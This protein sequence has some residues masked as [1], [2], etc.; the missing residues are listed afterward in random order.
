[1]SPGSISGSLQSKY[2]WTKAKVTVRKILKT[3][4]LISFVSC[5]FKAAHSQRPETATGNKMRAAPQTHKKTDGTRFNQWLCLNTKQKIYWFIIIIIIIITIIVVVVINFSDQTISV[6]FNPG[7]KAQTPWCSQC[8]F[9]PIMKTYLSEDGFYPQ[10]IK[11]K[12]CR[13]IRKCT[14]SLF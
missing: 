14:F 2:I 10:L 13:L 9:N 3:S 6:T 4:D 7:H 1:M 5:Q 12:Q 8:L 11:I